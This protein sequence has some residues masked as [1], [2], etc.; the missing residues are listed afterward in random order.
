ME[1]TLGWAESELEGF[2]ALMTSTY[3][4]E[5]RLGSRHG[6]LR[7]GLPQRLQAGPRQGRQQDRGGGETW[8]RFGEIVSH[9]MASQ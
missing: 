3:A 9:E 6:C 7:Q 4:P 1:M 2:H 8:E 5:P